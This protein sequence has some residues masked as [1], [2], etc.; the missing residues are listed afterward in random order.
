M[1][2]CANQN[3]G[4]AAYIHSSKVDGR[5]ALH[6]NESARMTSSSPFLFYDGYNVK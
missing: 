5:L 3:N 2:Q 6:S 1:F 4:T